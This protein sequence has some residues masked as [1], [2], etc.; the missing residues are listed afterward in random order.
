MYKGL[1][2]NYN[3]VPNTQYTWNHTWLVSPVINIIFHDY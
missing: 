2:T 1:D 3:Q